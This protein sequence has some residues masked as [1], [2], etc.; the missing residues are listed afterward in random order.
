[1]N[2]P[3]EVSQG[4]DGPASDGHR[5]KTRPWQHDNLTIN[6]L[7]ITVGVLSALGAVLFIHVMRVT[8]HFFFDVL[9]PAMT[10]FFGVAAIIL[11]PTLGGLLVAPITTYLAPETKGHGVPELM[12]AIRTKKGR[13][14]PRAALMKLLASAITLT[15]G[16][17]AGR[18]GPIVL[19]GGSIGSTISGFFNLSPGRTRRI[20]AC[21]CAAAIAVVFSAPLAGSIFAIEI[22]IGDFAV[23]SFASVVLSAVAGSIVGWYFLGS[24]PS[25]TIPAYGMVPPAEFGFF[26]VLGVLAAVV[27]L[28]FTSLLYRMEHI[29]DHWLPIPRVL[30][31]ALGGLLVGII[32]IWAPQVMGVG[33][34]YINQVLT[35]DYV[36]WLL[37]VLIVLK[38]LATSFTLGSGAS[39]GIMSPCLFMGAMLGTSFGSL[40]QRSLGFPMAHPGA[41]GLVGMAAVFG[42]AAQA[43]FT[44][45]ILIFE[46]TRD[47]NLIVPVMFGVV[48]ATVIYNH[49]RKTTIYTQKLLRRGVYYRVAHEVNV[50]EEV[51]VGEIMHKGAESIGEDTPY[52]EAY[53]IVFTSHHNGFPVVD[54]EGLLVGIITEGDFGHHIITDRQRAHEVK[55]KE[56]MCTHV[57]SVYPDMSVWEVH[58]LFDTLKIGRFPVV[59]RDN[60]REILGIVTRSDIV[61]AYP[62]ALKRHEMEFEI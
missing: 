14:R 3:S 9:H 11:I 21:G 23:R 24:S 44:S 60:P 20:I 62:Q 36:I 59:S 27:A 25:F 17:S 51:K 12:M 30:K 55:L 16:G 41:Y 53:R 52:D 56:I 45:T 15:S 42:A 26:L 57:K 49:F 2:A 58:K 37:L 31:P 28:L 48:V 46:M 7:A 38:P 29:F 18:E 19:I 4:R 39:G 40:V 61:H 1:M 50:L 35:G 47:Y 32:A 22:I 43:P 5:S 6:V 10:P 34:D 13:L 33:Y 8:Q 54:S